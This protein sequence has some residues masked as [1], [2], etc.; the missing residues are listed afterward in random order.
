[1]RILVPRSMLIQSDARLFVP[2]LL[3]VLVRFLIY[4]RVTQK[5]DRSN[6]SNSPNPKKSHKMR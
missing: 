1:M 2:K 6:R 5:T 3:I 4:V